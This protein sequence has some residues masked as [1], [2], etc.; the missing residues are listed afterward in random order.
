MIWTVMNLEEQVVVGFI[1]RG[2]GY[3]DCN[4]MHTPL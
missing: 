3:E 4:S 1:S 2:R